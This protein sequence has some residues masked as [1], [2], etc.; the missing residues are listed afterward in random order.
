MSHQI[1]PECHMSYHSMFVLLFMG[2]SN[3]KFLDPPLLECPK[4]EQ[5]VSMYLLQSAK[6]KDEGAHILLHA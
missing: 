1:F 5:S 3:I 2:P 6:K 4:C